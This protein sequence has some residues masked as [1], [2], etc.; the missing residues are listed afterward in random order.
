MTNEYGEVTWQKWSNGDSHD[1]MRKSLQRMY[2]LG[3]DATITFTDVPERDRQMLQD[4]FP[5]LN[6]GVD[7]EASFGLA[8]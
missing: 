6:E 3:L 7:Q 4:I 2:E 1:E 5:R 8:S